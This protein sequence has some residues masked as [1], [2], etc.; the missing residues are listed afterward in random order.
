MTNTVERVVIFVDN[1]KEEK[2]VE[3]Y[4]NDNNIIY[5]KVAEDV[6]GQYK[7]VMIMTCMEISNLCL[8]RRFTN[9]NDELYFSVV[10]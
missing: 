9:I 8:D 7:Y 10:A 6:S 5:K 2:I 3:N 1:T 4:M